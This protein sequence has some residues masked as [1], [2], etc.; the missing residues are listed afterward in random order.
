M[1]FEIMCTFVYLVRVT[2]VHD[3]VLSNIESRQKQVDFFLTDL[4]QAGVLLSV[5][6]RNQPAHWREERKRMM[7]YAVL[8]ISFARLRS[9]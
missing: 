5:L 9:S 6:A 1:V 7:R 2:T 8:A 4:L 3:R